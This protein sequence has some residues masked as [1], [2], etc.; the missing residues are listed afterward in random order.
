MLFL[1]DDDGISPNYVAALAAQ[2]EKHP[3]AVLG[4]GR[5][6]FVDEAGHVLGKSVDALPDYL[7]GPDFIRATWRQYA[8][9]FQSVTPFLGKTSELRGCGGWVEFTRGT[10]MDDALVVK[11]CLRGGVVFS[12]DCV[13]RN[14]VDGA[15]S[16]WSV[17][18][19]ELAAAVREF[20]Y[21]L[22][23][24]PVT[25][26]YA[27]AHPSDWSDL[28]NCLVEMSWGAYLWR[29]RDIYRQ[30]LSYPKWVMAAFA[31]PLIPAFYRR[32]LPILLKSLRRP[33]QP[34]EPSVATAAGQVHPKT[35]PPRP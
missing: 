2:L 24:D 23:R 11:M 34:K 33:A 32:A 1:P 13:Y 25:Q 4:F 18:A 31:L 21:F 9:R 26:N 19:R 10:H 5:Q 17:S 3:S 20:H 22:E 27:R 8:F 30:R 35:T 7:S 16:G 28:R 6:E 15:S 29:W 12:S 14:L